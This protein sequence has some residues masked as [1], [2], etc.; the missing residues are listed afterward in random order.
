MKKIRNS[1]RGFTLT[2]ILIVVAIV[3]VL[4][5]AAF[6][7]VAITLENARNTNQKL[8][9]EHGD[10]FELEARQA[11]RDITANAAEF[12]DIPYY[13]PD[14]NSDTNDDDD[15]NT[16]NETGENGGGGGGGGSGNTEDGDTTGVS[17]TPTATATPSP[18]PTPTT[19]PTTGSHSNASGS[20]FDYKE[21]WSGYQ[22][23]A[24]K[25]SNGQVKSF[26]IVVVGEKD[27]NIDAYGNTKSITKLADGKYKIVPK[28]NV[29][30]FEFTIGGLSKDGK[31]EV[32]IESYE[33]A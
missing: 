30:N 14:N 10:N 27:L 22:K 15:E 21:N 16:E 3:V 23:I 12:F 26:V 4:S 24:T 32:Y 11:V 6:V 5:S 2:E 29:S 20:S 8:H 28:W 17:P 9:D 1:K 25:F 33:K 31:P 18:S 19:A 7:G 13:T